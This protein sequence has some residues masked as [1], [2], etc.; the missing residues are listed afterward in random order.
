[1]TIARPKEVV[2][3]HWSLYHQQ[4]HTSKLYTPAVCTDLHRLL[5][6]STSTARRWRERERKRGQGREGAGLDVEQRRLTADR[7]A[8]SSYDTRFNSPFPSPVPSQ[9]RQPH[10]IQPRQNLVPPPPGEQSR[11][12][13]FWLTDFLFEISA[14]KLLIT[15]LAY[16]ERNQDQKR[17][18]KQ[19]R[20]KQ[21]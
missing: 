8:V 20:T 11:R 12:P 2:P 16:P 7:R 17:K 3:T 19:S 4:N 1:M 15:T 14:P 21:R 6:P 9:A 13:V 10:G 18:K 5:S